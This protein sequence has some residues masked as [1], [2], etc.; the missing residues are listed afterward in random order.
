MGSVTVYRYPNW[1]IPS[2]EIIEIQIK[3]SRK[4]MQVWP[5]HPEFT[6]G[7]RMIN[8]GLHHINKAMEEVKKNG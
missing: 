6:K 3:M 2:G 4:E 8:D 1:K 5:D 7:F